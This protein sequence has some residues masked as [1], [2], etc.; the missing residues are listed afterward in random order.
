MDFQD[1]SDGNVVVFALSG[2]IMSCEDAIPIRAKIKEYLEQNKKNF[3]IDMA[4][5]PWMNSDGLGLLA[6]TRYLAQSEGDLSP[7]RR[8]SLSDP[9]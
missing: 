9:S 2:K 3:V 4:D 5:V 8:V 6:S 7:E 1:L